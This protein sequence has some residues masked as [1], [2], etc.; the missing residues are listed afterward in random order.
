[1][2][3]SIVDSVCIPVTSVPVSV[4][5]INATVAELDIPVDP[6]GGC[7]GP[8]VLFESPWSGGNVNV[9][10]DGD[11]TTAAHG[12]WTNG[13]RMLAI[14]IRGRLDFQSNCRTQHPYRQ[15]ALAGCDLGSGFRWGRRRK[16]G[17]LK[18]VR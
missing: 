8:P 1:V 7:F 6:I 12:D 17:E 10:L 11:I 14:G 2:T 16:L 18:A 13:Q 3:F 9:A 15:K 5:S 4:E